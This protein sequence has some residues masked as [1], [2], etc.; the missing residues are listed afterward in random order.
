MTRRKKIYSLCSLDCVVDTLALWFKGTLSCV[1]GLC[2]S[3]LLPIV[4]SRQHRRLLGPKLQYFFKRQD[5]TKQT[6]ISVTQPSR[7]LWKI[8]LKR[9]VLLSRLLCLCNHFTLLTFTDS[10]IK[11]LINNCTSSLPSN[12]GLSIQTIIFNTNCQ[13]SKK[14]HCRSQDNNPAIAWPS[15]PG[16]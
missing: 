4:S 8:C 16:S 15:T 3:L 10:S 7:F 12:S 5:N 14:W 11:I 2:V 13:C 6:H 9:H 1:T